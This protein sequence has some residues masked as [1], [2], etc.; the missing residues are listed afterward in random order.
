VAPDA[1][2]PVNVM[3]NIAHTHLYRQARIAARLIGLNPVFGFLH[4]PR[5]GFA[6][7]AADLQE[8]FRMLMDRAVIETAYHVQP[9]DFTRS[10]DGPFPLQM[11]FSARRRLLGSV[12]ETLQ[13]VADSPTGSDPATYRVHLLRLARSIRRSLLGGEPNLNVFRLASGCFSADPSI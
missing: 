2:D 8:P 11:S 7:L 3:L 10:E 5:S 9:R 6:P 1:R 12:Y 4:R 13:T